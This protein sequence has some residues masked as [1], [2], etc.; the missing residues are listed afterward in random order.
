MR[1][2]TSHLFG[3]YIADGVPLVHIPFFIFVGRAPLLSL[4]LC[5]MQFYC[6]VPSLNPFTIQ[7]P[8]QRVPLNVLSLIYPGIL[9]LVSHTSSPHSP[10]SHRQTHLSSQDQTIE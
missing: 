4:K 8:S 3:K 9:V 10:S 6:N 5:K 7:F 2:N 1:W